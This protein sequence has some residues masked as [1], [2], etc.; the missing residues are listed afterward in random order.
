MFILLLSTVFFIECIFWVCF[1]FRYR[2]PQLMRFYL[3]HVDIHVM[4]LWMALT[5]R[6]TSH[7]VCCLN[8]RTWALLFIQCYVNLFSST[9]A[10]CSFASFETNAVLSDYNALLLKVLAIFRPAK[11]CVS[12]FVDNQSHIADSQLAI[13]VISNVL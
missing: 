11:F 13:G 10:H 1:C 5:S 7:Q 3:S 9:E 2:L 6:F 12:M 4:E 8:M